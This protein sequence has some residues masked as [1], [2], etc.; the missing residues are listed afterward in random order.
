LIFSYYSIFIFIAEFRSRSFLNFLQL[1]IKWEL[2]NGGSLLTA[3][4]SAN[5]KPNENEFPVFPFRPGTPQVKALL[6]DILA[7]YH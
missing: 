3:T 2:K 5:I 1:Y 6:P 4:C 7:L